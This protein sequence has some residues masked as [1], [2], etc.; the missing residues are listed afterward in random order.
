MPD[1]DALV[2]G[3]DNDVLTVRVKRPEDS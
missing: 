2:V 3:V 1:H